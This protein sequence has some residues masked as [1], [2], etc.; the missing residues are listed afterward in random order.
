[1]TPKYGAVPAVSPAATWDEESGTL[2]LF[3]VNRSPDDEVVLE[4]DLR[5]LQPDAVAEHLLLAGDDI[6][7]TNTADA[8]DRVQL[9]PGPVARLDGHRLTVA[10]PAVSWTALT[11]TCD[12]SARREVIV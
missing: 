6:R 3:L 2:A 1:V 4:I 10:L 5:A 11:L 9:Q 7:T 12:K 8:P